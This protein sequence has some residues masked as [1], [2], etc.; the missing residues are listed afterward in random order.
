MRLLI[1]LV[2]NRS[3]GNTSHKLFQAYCIPWPQIYQLDF[4]KIRRGDFFLQKKKR[5]KL[6]YVVDAVWNTV[7]VFDQAPD[8]WLIILADWIASDQHLIYSTSVYTMYMRLDS[9]AGLRIERRSG[10]AQTSWNVYGNYDNP[11][12]WCNEAIECKY[13]DAGQRLLG[14]NWRWPFNC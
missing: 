9:T 13:K 8:Q 5:K 10:A 6:D 4:Y 1:G 2:L 3:R 7:L 12:R 14:Q 11:G